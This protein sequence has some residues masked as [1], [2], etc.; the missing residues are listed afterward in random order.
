MSWRPGDLK[1]W[2]TESGVGV[3]LVLVRVVR[4]GCSLVV[5]VEVVVRCQL[6]AVRWRGQKHAAL[7]ALAQYLKYG[8]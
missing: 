6:R 4:F 8:F 5:F 3:R 7:G 2:C 1:R